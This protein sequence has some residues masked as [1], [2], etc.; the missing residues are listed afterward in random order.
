ML[1][2]VIK[3]FLCCL[4]GLPL[5]A[6]ADPSP[7]QT[8]E[9][10]QVVLNQF[11]P[12]QVLVEEANF[13]LP[14]GIQSYSKAN[15]SGKWLLLGGRTNGLHGFGS[16]H[17]N[18]PIKKQNTKVYVVDPAT[19]QTY[20]R[21]LKAPSAHL[22][23]AQI[24]VLSATNAQDYVRGNTLY[25]TGGYGI[26]SATGQFTTKDVLTA[27]DI[28]GLMSWVMHPVPGQTAAQYI[29]QI[30]NPI[31]QVTGGEMFQINNNPTLLVFGQN[32]TGFYNP[33]ANGTY[34]K[35][36]RRFNI[37]DDGFNLS[38]EV[39]TPKRT[40]ENSAFRRRDL[41]VVPVVFHRHGHNKPGLIVYGGVFTP[42]V[43]VWTVPVE[44]SRHGYPQMS[45]PYHKTTFKQ[46][47]NHY[48]CANLGLYSKKNKAMHTV[49]FGGIS[50]GFIVDGQF[51]FDDEIP[52]INQITTI[53]RDKYGH[54]T[55]YLMD[56]S[57]PVIPSTG[58]NPGNPLLFGA[59]AHLFLADGIP[60]FTD[61]VLD[62]D[63]M[64]STPF[65]VGHIV[66]GVQ[67]TVPN[68]TTITDSQ[69]SPHIF[70]VTVFPNP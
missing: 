31:F 40:H 6:F 2:S 63:A 3:A 54:Y 32:F 50:Y 36:I 23:Q 41:N 66:G 12:F 10:S 67:S 20:S 16:G 68:T 17:N 14:D 21:S 25:I 53:T 51:E 33:S 44:I 59:E 18:F 24:D 39:L 62:L 9:L 61:G 64:G 37:I 45:N 47:M 42:D 38:V 34:V 13:T 4:G 15:Y 55:Q 7:N 43:G 52:F 8:Q 70:K 30:S 28:P 46:S 58:P 49:L 27:I 26:D 56:A 1:K 29:R 11:T 5:F 22:T 69:A 19:G 48:A 65:V 57:Y 60:I 35:Q